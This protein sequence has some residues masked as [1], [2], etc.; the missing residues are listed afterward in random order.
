MPSA[1]FLEAFRP[2]MMGAPQDEAVMIER[3]PGPGSQPVDITALMQ[4]PSVAAPRQKRTIGNV[5]SDIFSNRPDA[6]GVPTSEKLVGLGD[7]F[8]N[9]GRLW[10]GDSP[11]NTVGP[12]RQERLRMEGI[13]DADEARNVFAELLLNPS[14]EAEAAAARIDPMGVLDYRKQQAEVDKSQA[15]LTRGRVADA[16]AAVAGSEDPAALWSQLAADFDPEVAARIGQMLQ[17]GIPAERLAQAYGFEAPRQGTQPKELQIYSMLQAEDPALADS[18]LKSIA[19]PDAMTE[20]QAAMLQIALGNFGLAQRTADREDRK[21]AITEE[22]AAR[23]AETKE[24]KTSDVAQILQDFGIRVDGKEDPVADLIKDSTSGWLQYGASMIPGAFGYSTKGQENIGR[25]E[26]IDNALVLAI[27]GGKLGAGVSNA[28]RDFFKEM[29]GKISD[30]TIPT[31]Q[32]LA[33]WDQVKGRLRGILNRESTP[34]KAPARTNSSGRTI[35]GGRVDPR[36]EAAMR[37][38]GMTP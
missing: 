17:T 15:E 31:G 33:A 21:L 10:R 24:G 26:T 9:A 29:S 16:L 4:G 6:R 34:A 18:Y 35:R 13:A 28:D 25:L 30:P 32:R 2:Y 22:K 11:I 36:L 7:A 8:I 20:Q 12:M 5:L 23:E 3:A 1:Q 27:A 14:P 37:K 38:K 19:N